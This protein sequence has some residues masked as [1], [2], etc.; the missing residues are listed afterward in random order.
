MGFWGGNSRNDV[1]RE[2]GLEIEL[3]FELILG[4]DFD[5]DVDFFELHDLMKA[6]MTP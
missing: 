6:S 3:G 4:L 5:L 2:L 1:H